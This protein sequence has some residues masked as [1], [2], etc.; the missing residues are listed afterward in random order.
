MQ[1]DFDL[2]TSATLLEKL[3][4]RDDQQAWDRFVKLYCP[5]LRAWG[6]R[7]GLLEND[8]EDLIGRLLLKL[9]QKLPS[10]VYNPAQSFR[11]WL[12]T[13]VFHEVTDMAREA[14]HR[15]PGEKGTG[16][17]EIYDLLLQHP[18]GLDELV[19]GLHGP[20]IQKLEALHEAMKEVRD[21]C[22]GD[23]KVSWEIFHRK[24]LMDEQIAIL[25]REFSLTVQN[26]GMRVVRMKKRIEAKSAQLLGERA[27]VAADGRE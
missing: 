12:R 22:Q 26:A 5:L 20:L 15:L 9:F 17:S 11:G 24:V 8:V 7:F 1:S 25:A 19:E 23:Q 3:R 27:R 2:R 16:S 6:K 18:D 13:L 10:F 14:K 4:V 21:A